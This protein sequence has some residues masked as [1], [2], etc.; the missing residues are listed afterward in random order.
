MPRKQKEDTTKEEIQNITPVL[1]ST[2]DKNASKTS[3]TS[4]VGQTISINLKKDSYFG[5]GDIWLTQKNYWAKIPA[6]L[7]PA[8]YEVIRRALSS[9]L[10]VLGKKYLPQ[11]EKNKSTVDSFWKLIQDQKNNISVHKTTIEQF[12]NLLK[13]QSVEGWTVTE[14]VSFCKA[15]ERESKNRE[16]VLLFL[17][18]VA[19]MYE[20]PIT[21][22]EEPS[23]QEGKKT[24]LPQDNTE[25]YVHKDNS[26]AKHTGPINQPTS[27]T[28][29]I[30]DAALKNLLG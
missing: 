16:H 12:R 7:T 24:V 22:T 28:R 25:P 9:G 21:L 30:S 29:L 18:N 14:I 13:K 10:I 15:K 3:R 27:D 8:A 2:L 17:K 23:E 5:V 20:G 19:D 11:V 1:G 6:G 26:A 4:L